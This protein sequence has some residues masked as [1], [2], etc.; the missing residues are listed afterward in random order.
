V[1]GE[2]GPQPLVEGEGRLPEADEQRVAVGGQL[3]QVQA[4]VA[5]I[6]AAG[7]QPGCLHRVQVVGE[8]GAL[9]ADRFG[10]LAL[11]GQLPAL[12]GDEHQPD[13]QRSRS[14]GQGVVEGAAHDSRNPGQVQAQR[15]A[16][17]SAHEQSISAIN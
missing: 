10:E 7:D 1:L 13:R 9:D 8:R 14:L 5:G 3:H 17:W 6:P 16:C 15:L 2:P 11:A 12:D 4:A